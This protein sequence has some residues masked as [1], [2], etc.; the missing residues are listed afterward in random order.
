[1][2]AKSECTLLAYPE[3][4]V[5]FSRLGN[6]GMATAGAG[7]VLA[8]TIAGLVSQTEIDFMPLLGT[9][10]HG[11][12]GDLAYEELGEGLLAGDIIE[13]LPK[14][15]Q[16]LLKWR[17]EKGIRDIERRLFSKGIDNV[18]FLA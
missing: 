18:T 11:R 10:L 2:V 14:A 8:G 12:A 15:R 16:E 13:R 9:Y 5:F 17:Q 4:E 7:D 3:G 6:Q 1:V